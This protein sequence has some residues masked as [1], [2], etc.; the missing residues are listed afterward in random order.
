LM[1]MLLTARRRME[2]HLGRT[3]LPH[4]TVMVFPQ[5]VFSIEAMDCLRRAGYLAAANTEVADCRSQGH[6][7]LQ[8]LLQPAVSCYEGSPL[9]AR[10]RPDDGIVNFAVDSFL[11]KPC[12]V[13]LHHDFFKGGVK[14][15]EEFVN[16]LAN[17]NPKLS[18]SNLENIVH[19]CT[20]SRRGAD[21]RKIIRIFADRAA[22]QVNE[23]LTVVKR[24]PDA[25]KI[26]GVNI[27]GELVDFWFEDGFLK[28]NLEP[29][30]NRP[31]WVN[32]A[33][34]EGPAPGVVEDSLRE[35]AR[36][37]LRRY[38]CEFRDN[39]LAQSEI[40]LRTVHRVTRS[41]GRVK[42]RLTA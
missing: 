8:D 4:Q 32:I 11:G 15:L 38:L 12:L 41:L 30:A 33:T 35:K 26:R 19:R 1:S 9:F 29:S 42:L 39:S 22:I 2:A 20:M 13:V 17:I 3:S 6:L 18:W 24:E 14:K 23:Q 21:G 40:L 5:G 36:I 25:E 28:W 37:A 7:T 31:I 34:A 27:D 16:A 10:R